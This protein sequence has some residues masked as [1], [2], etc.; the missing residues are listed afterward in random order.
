VA[1][2][3]NALKASIEMDE[4]TRMVILSSA[5]IIVGKPYDMTVC[6]DSRVRPLTLGAASVFGECPSVLPAS[7]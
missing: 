6:Y 2:I 5:D 4:E 3:W 1:E 7:S